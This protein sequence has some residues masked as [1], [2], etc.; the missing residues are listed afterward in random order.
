MKAPFPVL[1]LA[2]AA[3]G[4]GGPTHAATPL[5]A[6]MSIEA[7]AQIGDEVNVDKSTDA[8]GTV[9]GSLSIGAMAFSADAQSNSATAQGYGNAG[10]ASANAGAVSFEGYGWEWGVEVGS[11]Q[12]Q[13]MLNTAVPDWSYTFA[14]Q[15]GDEQFRVDYNVVAGG[16]TFGLQ[17][18]QIVVTGGPEFEQSS[19]IRDVFDPTTSGTFVAGLT[20][21]NEYTVMLVNNANLG[22]PGFNTSGQMS[23]NFRWEISPIPEPGTYALM[24]L[25][26][27]AVGAAARRRRR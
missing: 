15:A 16:N 8:W 6:S 19:N 1:L 10:W 13:V 20:A 4:L 2:A 25:G 26:L 24:A 27:I 3:A 17:G 11:P 5:A 23:G 12:I 14:A 9:L 22:G 18:W 7:I 21:G